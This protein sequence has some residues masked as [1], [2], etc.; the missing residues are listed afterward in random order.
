MRTR[1]AKDDV[2]IAWLIRRAIHEM[3]GREQS[4]APKKSNRP[5]TKRK[6]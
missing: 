5:I 1:A 4:S 6:G 2:S 3:I